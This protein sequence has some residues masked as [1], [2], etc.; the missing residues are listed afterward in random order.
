MPFSQTLK[1]RNARML[2]ERLQKRQPFNDQSLA[3]TLGTERWKE[4]QTEVNAMMQARL[5]GQ[6]IPQQITRAMRRY[7][8][9]LALADQF[10]RKAE[11]TKPSTEPSLAVK[12]KLKLRGKLHLIGKSSCEI[13]RTR[14]ETAYESAIETL[15]EIIEEFPEVVSYL[16]KRPIFD[17]DAC[18]VTPDAGSMPRMR[19]SRLLRNLA[20]GIPRQSIQQLKIGALNRLINDYGICE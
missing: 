8:E 6:A 3:T 4:L 5:D 12:R 10:E 19:N 9:R 16:N 1:R 15:V 13:Y 7:S 11:L 2:I 18:N 14:A 20:P 17:G